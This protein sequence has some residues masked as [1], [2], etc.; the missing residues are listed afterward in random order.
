MVIKEFVV[1]N[2][3]VGLFVPSRNETACECRK[4]PT[5]VLNDLYCSHKSFRLMKIEKNKMG[6]ACSVYG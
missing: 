3:V 1:I 4:I 6:G 2:C 5:G